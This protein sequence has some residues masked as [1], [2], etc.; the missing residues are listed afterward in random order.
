[1]ALARAEV[2]ED[3]SWEFLTIGVEPGHIVCIV[4]DEQAFG[5]VQV[6]S[7]LLQLALHIKTGPGLGAG[8][9][10]VP[11]VH[12]DAIESTSGLDL[13]ASLAADCLVGHTYHPLGFL[14]HHHFPVMDT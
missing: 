10:L 9:V 6:H 3:L 2:G 7:H 8:A 1:M 11:V 12:D 14:R 13:D 5:V 4:E